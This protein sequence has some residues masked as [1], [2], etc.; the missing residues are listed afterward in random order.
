MS[1]PTASAPRRQA[2]QDGASFIAGGTNL[3]DLMKLE[4][5]APERLVDIT[6]LDLGGV[7]R[8]ANRRAADRGAGHQCRSCRRSRCPPRLSG[9]VARAACRGL[10]QLRNKATTGGNLLQRTRCYYFY[11]TSSPATSATRQRLR[12]DRRLQPHPCDPGRQR[13]VHRHASERHGGGAARARRRGRDGSADGARRRRPRSGS[14]PAAGR[15]A[16]RETGSRGRRTHHRRDPAARTDRPPGLPQGA[17]SR[18][19]RL[20]ARLAGQRGRDERRPDRPR[21]ARL[22]RACAQALARPQGRGGAGRRSALRGA[23]RPRRRQA[24][25]RRERA[26]A[27]TISRYLS[28]AGC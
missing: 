1:A 20:R 12:R 18:L 9:P 23:F 24:P 11:D 25:A 10:G 26:G 28:R 22:R 4:V 7:E 17:R 19:L 16:E 8:T 13:A 3:L 15:H 14:A 5:M 2:A 6:R 21:R 27:A